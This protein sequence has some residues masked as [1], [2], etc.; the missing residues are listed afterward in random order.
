MKTLTQIPLGTQLLFGKAAK[1]RRRI[2]RAI[3]SVFERWNYDEI[4]PPIFD[5]Y[6]VFAQRHGSCV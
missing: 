6:D 3:F 2:E 4:I 1:K 5:Y